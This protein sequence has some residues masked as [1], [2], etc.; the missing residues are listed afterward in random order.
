[1]SYRIIV[2]ESCLVIDDSFFG[3]V[4]INNHMAVHYERS[5]I[6]IFDLKNVTKR[7]I[8]LKGF[9][10]Y[11]TFLSAVYPYVFMSKNDDVGVLK[12]HVIYPDGSIDKLERLYHSFSKG[13]ALSFAR[14]S[15][16]SKGRWRDTD[17]IPVSV[18]IRDFNNDGHIFTHTF[19]LPSSLTSLYDSFIIPGGIFGCLGAFSGP[20]V[21]DSRTEHLDG[22]AFVIYDQRQPS[23]LTCCLFDAFIDETRFPI[24]SPLSVVAVLKGGIFLLGLHPY[25]G[26]HLFFFS[27]DKELYSLPLSEIN[28]KNQD[29]EPLLTV[30]ASYLDCYILEPTDYDPFSPISIH[31][32]EDFDTVAFAYRDFYNT[33]SGSNVM[34]LLLSCK[35]EEQKYTPYVGVS[36]LESGPICRAYG[37]ILLGEAAE[38]LPL[39]CYRPLKKEEEGKYVVCHEIESP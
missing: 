12:T 30:L 3:L 27:I 22:R 7:K 13:L 16:G 21:I 26:S 33:G 24:F 18:S 4:S 34:C 37:C 31:G 10:S 36:F 23:Q 28:P 32:L 2:D 38:S 17:G 9:Y 1:M 5:H 6:V 29:F 11:P 20:L 35:K 39:W 8:P 14:R 19:S 15:K 25:K